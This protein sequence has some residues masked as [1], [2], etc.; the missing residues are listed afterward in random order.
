MQLFVH[1]TERSDEPTTMLERS[2]MDEYQLHDS[3]LA[4]TLLFRYIKFFFSVHKKNLLYT[5]S[6]ITLQW[7]DRTARQGKR[8]LCETKEQFDKVYMH[9]SQFLRLINLRQNI[10]RC[11]N[12]YGLIY[13][14]C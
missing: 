13:M 4:Q 9:T 2:H 7:K 5:H 11:V 8:Y 3:C 6:K 1:D 12:I 14:C 10:C